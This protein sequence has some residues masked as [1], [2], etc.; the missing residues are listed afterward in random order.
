MRECGLKPFLTGR[1]LGIKRVTPYA[2][3]W[4][5]TEFRASL[6]TARI[7]TPYAG[8]WIET[9]ALGYFAMG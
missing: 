9:K 4:I 8:V 6:K 5:E 1:R 3:V 2:G 7:V